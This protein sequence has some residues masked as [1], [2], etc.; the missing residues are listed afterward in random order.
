MIDEIKLKKKCTEL[1]KGLMGPCQ[2]PHCSCIT[3]PLEYMHAT[4]EGEDKL[5]DQIANSGD[6]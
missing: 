3:L 5:R 1:F 2:F 6:C 4:P